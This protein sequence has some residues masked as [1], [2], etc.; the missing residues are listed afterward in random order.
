[1][2]M[3]DFIILINQTISFIDPSINCSYTM[4]NSLKYIRSLNLRNKG[5]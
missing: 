1:M 5:R 2:G 3:L 4:Q